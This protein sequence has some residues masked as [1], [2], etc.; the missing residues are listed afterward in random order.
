MRV[1]HWKTAKKLLWRHQSNILKIWEKC[2]LKFLLRLCGLSFNKISPKIWKLKA[3]TDAHTHRHTDRDH[4][5]ITYS[6][7]KW[8]NTKSRFFCFF[9]S[10]FRISSSVSQHYSFTIFF[11]YGGQNQTGSGFWVLKNGRHWIFWL[12]KDK[13]DR[14]RRYQYIQSY[15]IFF[16]FK[17][18]ATL[19]N[20]SKDL[21][22]TYV[23][24]GSYVLVRQ[25]VCS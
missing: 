5:G 21:A 25:C 22:S 10:K 2:H 7:L 20:F 15:D 18:F 6:V 8:L 3:W 17:I 1:P 24:P 13:H 9:C 14:S 11:K 4:P 19:N 16:Y 12:K 23:L